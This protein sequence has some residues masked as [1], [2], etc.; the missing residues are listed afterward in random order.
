MRLT[1]LH[2]LV[3]AVAALAPLVTPEPPDGAG[4]E[5]TES[6]VAF[7]GWPPSMDG[8]ALTPLALTADD[9]RFAG[10][11]GG[12]VARFTDGD[13]E[14]LIRWAAAPTR[15]LHPSAVCFRSAGWTIMP[16]PRHIDGLRREWTSYEIERDGVRRVVRER[17]EDS[18]GRSWPEPTDWYWASLL[19]EASGP[20]FSYTVV[21]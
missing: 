21:R 2:L 5:L 14:V 9:A 18:V 19:G 3:C 8:R 12:R 20:A 4:A 1:A 17:V 10:D 6:S 7:P 11:T 15:H 16:L 13:V